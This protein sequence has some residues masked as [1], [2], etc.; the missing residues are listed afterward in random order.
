MRPFK[1]FRVFDIQ[2]SMKIF[3]QLS[4]VFTFIGAAYALILYATMQDEKNKLYKRIDQIE[5]KL[6]ELISQKL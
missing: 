1:F 6:E 4:A 2:R 5:R 3:V